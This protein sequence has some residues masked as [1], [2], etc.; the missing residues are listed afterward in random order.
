MSAKDIADFL[1]SWQDDPLEMKPAFMEYKTFLEGVPGAE[2]EFVSRPGVSYSLRGKKDGRI[3]ALV[4]VVDDD[5]QN[6]WL[7]V[8]FYAESVK[9]VDELGDF[10]PQ[11]LLGED[12]ICFNLDEKDSTMREYIGERL[13]E[14]SQV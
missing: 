7:S 10:V 1:K 3:M 5:P 4:D 11:G 6:R 2:M 13:K 14:A 12:A 8:C 9:D